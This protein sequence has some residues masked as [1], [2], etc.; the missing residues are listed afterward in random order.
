MSITDYVLDT[1]AFPED[2]AEHLVEILD[3]TRS[4]FLSIKDALYHFRGLDD[5]QA[6]QVM[7]EIIELAAKNAAKR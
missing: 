5:D 6:A 2:Y 1:A 7:R 4:N 3:I